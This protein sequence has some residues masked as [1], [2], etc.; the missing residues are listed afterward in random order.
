MKIAIDIRSTSGERAG[1]GQYTFHLTQALLKQDRR[2]HYILYT[3]HKTL[4]YSHFPNVELREI[5]APGLLWHLKVAR[6]VAN[7]EVDVFWSPTS[8]ITPTLI[9]RPTQVWVT[10]HDLV[11][12]LYPQNHDKKAT[13]IEKLFLKRAVKRA[14]KI[15]AVS[16]HT[17]QDLITRFPHAEDKTFVVPCAADSI[18]R[19]LPSQEL[20]TFITETNLPKH[21]F[22][23]VGT[24]QPRKNYLN[25][26]RAFAHLHKK[27]PDLYLLIVGKEG[28]KYEEVYAEIT[29]HN[30]GNYVHVLGYLS[31]KSIRNLYNLA[32]ALVFP[33]FYEGFGIPALEAM[34]SGCPVIASNSSSLPEVVG[35][36]GLLVDPTK[37]RD[38]AQAM[39]R[40]LCDK[41]LRLSLSE[42]GL[43]QAKKFSWEGSAT[44]L[45][46]F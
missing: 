38:I 9:R 24:I 20:L 7:S 28:W 12:F 10:V 37:Y 22:L 16:N 29:R 19:P 30:L 43:E 3:D 6:D 21:F 11:A 42:K 39:S 45:K 35:N 26:I 1:K 4:G 33:S 31:D 8:Y 2:N 40:V 44:R 25:I 17:K 13:M 27:N 36:A 14:D 34:Q 41:N 18:Y 23:A 15:L 5:S 32:T 46:V